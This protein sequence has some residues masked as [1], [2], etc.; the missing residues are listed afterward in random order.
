MPKYDEIE[1][2]LGAPDLHEKIQV[3]L[4]NIPVLDWQVEAS[5]LGKPDLSRARLKPFASLLNDIAKYR[6]TK[7]EKIDLVVFPEVSVPHAWEAMIVA[8]ARK[9]RI[10]VVCGLE[11]RVRRSGYVR[12]EVLAALPYQAGNHH[13]GCIP[14]RRLKRF[15]S[16]DEAFVLTNE[17]LK[18]PQVAQAYHLFRW[19]GA[20]FAVYNC[21]ELASIE[22]RSLFKG[23]VDFIVG[24]EFNRDVPYF[25]NI[26]ESAARDLH[27]YVIQVNDSRFG[28]SRVVSPSKSEKMSP[29]RIKGGEN[30]T[31][32]TTKLDLKALR[33]HQRKG[34]G[35][36]KE[37]D[38]FK[39]TPP[40][41]NIKDVRFRIGLG[42]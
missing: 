27:C 8:W 26:V 31:F 39:P 17:G 9:H 11:H 41:F 4:A 33:D 23:K 35:L 22:D 16:P 28:D 29:L 30:L 40:G 21:Y 18:V 14:V 38:A 15:Y 37:S 24:T 13:W 12:N 1:V 5:Y 34:Y 3:A 10:G 42:K 20:S 32:L 6:N 19:R 2:G 25:S 7:R 36:Q